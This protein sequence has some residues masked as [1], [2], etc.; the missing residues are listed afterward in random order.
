MPEEAQSDLPQ[1]PLRQDEPAI[2]LISTNE[3]TLGKDMQILG[4][5]A[6]EERVQSLTGVSLLQKEACDS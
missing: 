1:S 3:P 4:E 5:T 2:V 6:L